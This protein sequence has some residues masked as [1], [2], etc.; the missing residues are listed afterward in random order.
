MKNKEIFL[1]CDCGA[2]VLR[3]I[4]NQWCNKDEP[5]FD[6]SMYSYGININRSK[7]LRDRIRVAWHILKTGKVFDDEIILNPEE[8]EKVYQYLKENLNH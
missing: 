4:K 6:L 1:V 5:Y 7:S 3:I 2:C 8:A